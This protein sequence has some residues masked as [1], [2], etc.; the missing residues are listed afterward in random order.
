MLVRKRRLALLFGVESGLLLLA[1]VGSSYF[2]LGHD[3]F[4][5]LSARDGLLKLVL[6]VTVCQVCLS[7][8]DLYELRLLTGPS[9]VL[10]RL[11]QALGATSFI[12][13]FW[14]LI[15]PSWLIDRGVFFGA[16][17]LVFLLVAS[18]RTVS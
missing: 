18:W 6:V 13:A 9:E 8:V 11:I 4:S 2:L 12:L 15:A 1:V 10:L 14:Y 7:Y 17:L 3:A 5:A 16:V